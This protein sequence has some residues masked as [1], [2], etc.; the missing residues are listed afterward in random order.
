VALGSPGRACAADTPEKRVALVVGIS[1]YVH[2]PELANP[3]NDAR[4]VAATLRALNFEVDERYD[5]PNRGLAEAL[6]GFGRRAGQADVALLYYAGHGMQVGGVNYLIPAD[7]QL[8]REHD[9]VYEAMPVNLPLGELAQAH[10]IGILILDACRNNPFVDRLTRTGTSKVQARPGFTAIEDTPSDTLVAMA[11]RGDTVA[12]DGAGEHSPYTAALLQHLNQPGLEL[13]LFFRKVRDTVKQ[14]TDGRQEPYTFGTLGATPFYF[15]PRPPNRQPVLAS[16]EPLTI[17]DRSEGEPLRIGAPTDPDGDQ[18]FARITGLPRGGNIRIGERSVLIG[19]YLTVEQLA[20]TS[21]KPDGTLRGE[22]GTFEFVVMDGHG[23]TVNG[24]VAVTIRPS[25]LPPLAAAPGIV[26]VVAAPLRFER[27]SDPDGDPL[28]IT[29]S[30]VPERGTVRNGSSA[31]R[32]GD[33]LTAGALTALSFDAEQAAPGPAGA[34]AVT[35]DDGRGGRT[36]ARTAL[37]VV[38]PDA[39]P[40]VEPDETVWQSIRNSTDAA[41]FQA[42]LR[43]FARSGYAPLARRQM[44]QMGRQ[45]MAEGG[46]VALSV[47]QPAP[48]TPPPQPPQPPTGAMGAA[49]SVALAMSGSAGS[50]SAGSGSAGS[51]SSGGPSPQPQSQPQPQAQPPPP[52]GGAGGT[53]GGT[54]RTQGGGGSFQDC[55]TCPVMVRVPAGSFTMGNN[56]GDTAERP[57]HRVTIARPFAVAAYEITL[58]QW[59]ACVDDGAC[60]GLAGVA[61]V[62]DT[63]PAFNLHWK[64]ADVYV[65]WLSRKTGQRYRLLSEAEWE[66]AARAGTQG[67]YWWDGERGLFADCRTCGTPPHGLAPG[68]T[69]G[70]KAN[71]FGLHGMNGGVAEWVADCWNKDYRGAPDD[72]RA[73]Q[74]GGCDKRVLRGGSWRDELAVVTA[75]GRNSYDADVRYLNN[76]F[77]VARDL[78]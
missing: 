21:F 48:P 55:Q 9:L 62:S 45:G 75:S 74:T 76:G 39:K 54:A 51:G 58:G 64:D 44:E 30:E 49:G 5:L 28:T 8:E 20:A 1:R 40:V 72:G 7:A 69:G 17:A 14:T 6:R 77:R 57:A 26:R 41:D 34:F 11:T 60:S 56:R 16:V 18:L 71:P 67:P 4:A 73:W 37:E 46:A 63:I 53:S 68:E 22:A 43:L 61:G 50:G 3:A 78:N 2:A 31:V 38:Q 25:N 35:I 42:F 59:R 15:N 32:P 27:P 19:D 52:G 23:G 10:K 29:V 65:T 33:R 13:S 66:Y 24:R 47:R 12:E 70:F 36:T